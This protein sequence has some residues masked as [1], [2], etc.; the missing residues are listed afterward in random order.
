MYRLLIADDE[1]IMLASLREIVSRQYGE[2]VEVETAKSGRTAIELAESFHPDIVFMDIQ[3][4]GING[5]EAIRS[6]RAFNSSA[7]FYVLSAY[8]KFDYAKSAI[9]LGVEKYLMKPI[10]KSK[11][12]ETIDEAIAKVDGMREKHSDQLKMQEKLETVIPVVENGFVTNM[13]LSSDSQDQEYYKQLLDISENYAYTVVIQFGTSLENGRLTCT[14]GGR[15]KAQEAYASMRAV[16]KSYN[17]RAVIGPIL[18]DRITV[19]V[20]HPDDTFAYEERSNAIESMRGLLN[21][22][23]DSFDL[24]FRAGIGRICRFQDLRMSYQEAVSAIQN[25]KS[26]IAHTDDLVTHGYYVDD[27]P[28]ELE[29]DLFTVLKGGDVGGMRLRAEEFFD[30]IEKKAPSD[31]SSMRLKALELVLRAETD[32]FAAGAINYAY[33]SRKDYLGQIDALSSAEEIKVW[34]LDHLTRVTSAIRDRIEDQ[35][36][37]TVTKAKKY[38]Q[39]NFANEISLDDVSRAVNVSPYYFSK[40]FKEEVGV[41]F[42][43]YL[44]ELRIEKAKELLRDDTLPVREVSALAGYPDQNYFSRIFKKQTGLTPRQFRESGKEKEDV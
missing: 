43:E 29:R 42:I 23:Q 19:I 38:I 7:L 27:Y 33:N 20:P 12:I 37:S 21:R 32:A 25:S 35:S 4:P 31:L 1:G 28:I 24:K 18:S 10:S 44:T 6:I 41:N 40:L 8:D 17:P 36:E 3:M 26:R 22:L 16:F 9:A 13:L 15:L 14:V 39:E 2:T 30:W 34:F 5:L 11:V